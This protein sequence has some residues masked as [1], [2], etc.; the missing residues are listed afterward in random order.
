MR[1]SSP[2]N[3]TSTN[4][5]KNVKKLSIASISFTDYDASSSQ[6][7]IVA[8]PCPSPPSTHSSLTLRTPLDADSSSGQLTPMSASLDPHYAKPRS[9]VRNVKELFHFRPISPA[10]PV[11]VIVSEPSQGSIHSSS[12]PLSA[13]LETSRGTDHG[14][15]RLLHRFKREPFRN[16]ESKPADHEV[17]L[18]SRL[19]GELIMSGSSSYLAIMSSLFSCVLGSPGLQF[20]ATEG[21]HR[22]SQ[23][24][25]RLNAVKTWTISLTR[26]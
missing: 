22:S 13:S 21:R 3:N 11:S 23:E 14:H 10:S 18:K 8:S 1:G 5:P 25:E 26:D 15:Y 20:P 19:G 4:R 6:E 16:L 9:L 17:S 2:L 7:V 24:S 12:S